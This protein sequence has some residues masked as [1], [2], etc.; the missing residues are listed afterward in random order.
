[1]RGAKLLMLFWKELWELNKSSEPV[2]EG[3][4]SSESSPAE[5]LLQRCFMRYLS[6]VL[7]AIPFA[8]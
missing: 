3:E 8:N 1:M 7:D 6:A 5:E 2:L 4:E